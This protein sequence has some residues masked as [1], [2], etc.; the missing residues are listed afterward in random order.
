M[1][2][3]PD[4]VYIVWLKW[5]LMSSSPS[6][7]PS[8]FAGSPFDEIFVDGRC[9]KDFRSWRF[10]FLS[11]LCLFLCFTFFFF[12]FFFFLIVRLIVISFHI[13]P[14]FVFYSLLHLT[15]TYPFTSCQQ[16]FANYFSIFEIAIIVC[17]QCR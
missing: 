1:S 17:N 16:Y 12:F 13:V 4:L 11:C 7:W 6:P 8:H 3:V 10:N 2:D 5:W 9:L 14:D 15:N